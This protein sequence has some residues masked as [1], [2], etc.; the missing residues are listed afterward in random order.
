MKAAKFATPK[1]DLVENAKQDTI[2]F[3]M[4]CFIG[5]RVLRT[6]SPTIVESLIAKTLNAQGASAPAAKMDLL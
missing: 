2:F 5:Q 3:S 6:Q 1:M 4:F